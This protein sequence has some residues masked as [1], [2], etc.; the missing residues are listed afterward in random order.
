ML[1]R[2][3]GVVVLVAGAIAG[4]RVRARIEKRTA[5]L[6]LAE[7]V[8]VVDAS[9]SR[10][11][12]TCDRRCGGMDYAHVEYAAQLQFKR[13]VMAD[14]FRRI[15]KMDVP[16]DLHVE[17]S[18][19]EG[20][21]LRARLHVVDRRVGFFREGTHVL[22]DAVATRQMSASCVAA[23]DGL[24]AQLEARLSDVSEMVIAE[25][26]SGAERVA[27]LVL[28]DDAG[29]W[30]EANALSQGLTGVTALRRGRFECVAGEAMVSDTAAQ[31]FFDASPVA[32]DTTWRRHAA[33]FFQGNRYL[34]GSLVRHVLESADGD[35]VADLYAG[36]GLFAVA[37]AAQGARVVAVEGDS[38]SGRDLTENA[39]P[40]SETLE[41]VHGSVEDVTRTIRR[42]AVSTVVCDPPRTGLSPQ[43]LSNILAL[44]APCLVYVSCDPATLARDA[45]KAIAGG[46]RLLSLRGF[47]LFPNTSHIESVA[48]FVRAPGSDRS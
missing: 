40:F 9:P 45:A 31:L 17:A 23:V 15:G 47:D 35:R 12:P 25:N 42:G 48:V 46:Y 22:C 43:A 21:R 7:V 24:V 11:N 8:D 29:P 5:S 10:R 4:E 27:H 20:Y 32:A 39:R 28:R 36:V 3:D 2:H 30:R 16:P 18:P 26:V 19:E 38:V 41:V 6:I 34:T 14:A 1:A 13:D 33:S 44:D 37:L